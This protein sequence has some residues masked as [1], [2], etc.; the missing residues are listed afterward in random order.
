MPDQDG[1]ATTVHELNDQLAGT[2]GA[3][4]E[5]LLGMS[6]NTEANNM[7]IDAALRGGPTG[8][9]PGGGSAAPGQ[10]G[11]GGPPAPVGSAPAPVTP[12]PAPASPLEGEIDWESTKAANG[13]YLG[14]YRTKVDAVR[15]VA[16][17]VAMAKTAFTRSE[18]VTRENDTLKRELEQLRMRPVTTPVMAPQESQTPV[19]SRGNGTVA[20]PKLDA[21]LSKLKD[22]GTLE[23]EDL[24]NLVGA[25][26]A[27]AEETGRRA[28]REE[29][30]VHTTAARKEAERWGRVE[31]FMTEK[32]PES[33]NFTDELALFIKTHPMIAAGVSALIV[34]DKHEEA[35]AAA[36]EIFSKEQK[37]EPTFKPAPATRENVEKEIRLDAADQVRRE[38]V[39]SA[40]RDAGIIG[41]VGGGRGVHENAD[42]GPSEDE[43]GDAVARMRQ[44]DGSKWRGLV[45]RD[46]LNHPIFG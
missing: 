30:E 6:G 17:T 43:Y 2:I 16:N 14:K 10:P 32:Y 29:F 26:T 31:E 7:M 36:W 5:Q 27:H 34:Q 28:A 46:A 8:G 22:N 1:R 40:R 24:T 44:G 25:I 9:Q 12:T 4:V 23:A 11:T 21:V 41:T 38:A 39:E 37:I 42:P 3:A 20:N 13:L 15:G 19:P 33:V 18:E 35:T 45:F